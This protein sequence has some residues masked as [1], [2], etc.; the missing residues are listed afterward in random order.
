MLSGYNGSFNLSRVA[1]SVS[2]SRLNEFQLLP[3]PVAP[4]LWH[5]YSQ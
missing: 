2:V 5:S 1:V 3:V 4:A